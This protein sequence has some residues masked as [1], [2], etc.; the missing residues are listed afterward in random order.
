MFSFDVVSNLWRTGSHQI[1]SRAVVK[2]VG[3]VAVCRFHN[4]LRPRR[5]LKNG[6]L[7]AQLF[8]RPGRRMLALQATR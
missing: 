4:F 2:Q 3:V 5:I 7:D 6:A 1:R 8:R